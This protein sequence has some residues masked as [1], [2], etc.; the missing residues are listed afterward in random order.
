[1]TRSRIAG[2]GDCPF[3]LGDIEPRPI[4]GSLDPPE[5]ASQRASRSVQ[6]LLHGL[7]LCPT[8]RHTCDIV[9]TGHKACDVAKKLNYSIALLYA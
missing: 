7:P 4:H 5:S 9:A 8:D 2:E 1:L 3:P 6:P